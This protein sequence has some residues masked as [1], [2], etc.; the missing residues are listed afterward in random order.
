MRQLSPEER[1]E[2]ELT[3]EDHEP[4]TSDVAVETDPR[5]TEGEEELVA[6]DDG[7]LTARPADPRA[8][9]AGERDVDAGQ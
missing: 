4:E 7:E 6:S 3:D 1:R 5:L 8:L 9:T 2:W